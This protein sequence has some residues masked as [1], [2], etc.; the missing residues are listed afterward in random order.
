MSAIL[1]EEKPIYLFLGAGVSFTSGI[2]TA[3]NLARLV[4]EEIEKYD[5]EV[6]FWGKQ[7][8]IKEMADFID[9]RKPATK[10]IFKDLIAKNLSYQ[11]SVISPE[12]RMLAFLVKKK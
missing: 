7:L 11:A 3:N 8:G 4:G 12:Y 9:K 10:F 5:P 6:N 2:R 1:T